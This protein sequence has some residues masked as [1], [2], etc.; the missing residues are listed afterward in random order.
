MKRYRITFDRLVFGGHEIESGVFEFNVSEEEEPQE[1][2]I[3]I[4]EE[5]EI[6]HG[7]IIS[8]QKLGEE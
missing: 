1:K 2:A 3:D 7:N 8:I 5:R 4:L 6:V